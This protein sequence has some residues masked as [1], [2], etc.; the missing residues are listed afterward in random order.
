MIHIILPYLPPT[1]NN[2]YITKKKRSGGKIVTF[3]TLSKDGALFK[4]S[5]T[6]TL[7]SGG[8]VHMRGRKDRAYGL[9][10]LF[11]FESIYNSGWPGRTKNRYKRTDV[12][13]RVK[14][15]E[16]CVAS[17]S[18]VDDSQYFPILLSKT[19]GDK[20]CTHV[21][22]W[23]TEEEPDGARK[24]LRAVD[25]VQHYGALP[26]SEP[27]GNQGA[28]PVHEGGASGHAPDRKGRSGKPPR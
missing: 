11:V 9:A 3:R 19:E 5:A 23:D 13:N 24:A 10:L 25:A 7:L 26:E 27:S 1:T 2:A 28:P 4:S 18:G 21:W 12:T 8:L 20:E 16:D 17:A 22:I 15:L 14:L 6:V